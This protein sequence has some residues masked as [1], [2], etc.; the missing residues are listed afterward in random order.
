LHSPHSRSWAQACAPSKCV[1]DSRYRLA[2]I[3]REQGD[4]ALTAKDFRKASDEYL[5][6]VAQLGNSYKLPRGERGLDDTGMGLL[7]AIDEERH[8]DLFDAAQ[9]RQGEL[10]TRLSMYR[11]S[12]K[13]TD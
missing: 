3:N 11:W 1:E 8:A 13:C 12:R 10:Y 7:A 9:S 6:G 4:K 2:Y 5:K